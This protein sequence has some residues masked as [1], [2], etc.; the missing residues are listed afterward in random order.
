LIDRHSVN[1]TDGIILRAALDL[2]AALRARGDRLIVVSCDTRLL[3]AST[4]EGLAT[5]NPESQSE[6]DLDALLGP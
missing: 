4:T 2:A 5:F 1:S 3:K 6:T